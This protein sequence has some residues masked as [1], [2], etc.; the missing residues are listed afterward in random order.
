MNSRPHTGSDTD[1]Y[2]RVP[3]TLGIIVLGVGLYFAWDQAKQFNRSQNLA[4]WSDVTSRTFDV[5][6]VFIVNPDLQ[7]YFFAGVDTK[8]GDAEF[9]KASAIAGIMLDYL[10]S[11]MTRLEYN[12]GHLPEDIL[13]RGTWDHYFDATFRTSPIL[14]RTLMNDPLSYG[15][16]M[17]RWRCCM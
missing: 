1:L 6:K 17:R 12:K 11:V 13:Q 8:E 7:R 4:N 14:C 5:D 10:D 2:K 15:T 3:D 9:S 16:E